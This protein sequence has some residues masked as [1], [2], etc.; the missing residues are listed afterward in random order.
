[1]AGELVHRLKRFAATSGYD[2]L[3]VSA[4]AAQGGNFWKKQGLQV[5]LFESMNPN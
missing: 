3:A 4:H 5:E 2:F 1:V